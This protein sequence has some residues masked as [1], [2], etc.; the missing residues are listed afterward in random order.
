MNSH[1]QAYGREGG[2]AYFVV[3]GETWICPYLFLEYLRNKF[4]SWICSITL[5]LMPL[6]Q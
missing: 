1:L 5:E 3:R 2:G 4:M 6:L